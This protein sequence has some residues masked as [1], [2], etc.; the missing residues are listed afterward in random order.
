VS[1]LFLLNLIFSDFVHIL[2]VAPIGFPFTLQFALSK[3]CV[4]SVRS[5]DYFGL[6]VCHEKERERE[7][8]TSKLS[9]LLLRY[10]SSSNTLFGLKEF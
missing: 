10:C 2:K 4:C 7:R 8:I 1:V 9:R 3:S 5:E 6:A